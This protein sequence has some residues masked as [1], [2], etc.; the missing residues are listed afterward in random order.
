VIENFELS[1]NL[2]KEN[3]GRERDYA[4]ILGY[5]LNHKY[6]I[7]YKL[8]VRK[9]LLRIPPICVIPYTLEFRTLYLF[10]I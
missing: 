8:Y 7:D 2:N 6:F 3:Q 9:F 4:K 1:E 10:L 5:I